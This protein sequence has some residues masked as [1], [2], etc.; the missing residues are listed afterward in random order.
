VELITFIVAAVYVAGIWKF[1]T[2]FEKTNFSRSLPNR[3]GL[4]L[5]WPILLI[6][7]KSYRGNFRR[8]LKG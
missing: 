2:G 5:L 1:W 7:S 8:A 3:I 4:A 6:T